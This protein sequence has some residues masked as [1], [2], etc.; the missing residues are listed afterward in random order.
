MTRT[1]AINRASSP[2]GIGFAKF[3]TSEF[4]TPAAHIIGLRP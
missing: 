4:S 2:N 1:T 3:L